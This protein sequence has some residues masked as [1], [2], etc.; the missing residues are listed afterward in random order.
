MYIECIISAF[1][2]VFISQHG[3]VHLPQHGTLCGS[4]NVVSV[5]CVVVSGLL[6][7]PHSHENTFL[8]N[9]R[10]KHPI[11]S[12]VQIIMQNRSIC[13]PFLL[14]LQ[15]SCELIPRTDCWLLFI[16]NDFFISDHKCLEGSK[17]YSFFS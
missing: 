16:L 8:A 4:I 5:M 11:L 13:S 9:G 2:I 6:L 17:C 14:H 10:T 1:N 3:P 7:L 12:E 15:G